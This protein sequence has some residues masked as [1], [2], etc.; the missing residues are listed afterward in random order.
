GYDY[1]G[2]AAAV[3][4]FVDSVQSVWQARYQ[5]GARAEVLMAPRGLD[6]PRFDRLYAR[7]DDRPVYIAE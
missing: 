1:V 4:P 5:G 2:E 6:R 7:R 3:Q